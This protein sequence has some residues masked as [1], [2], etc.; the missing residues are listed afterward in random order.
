MNGGLMSGKVGS[1]PGDWERYSNQRAQSDPNWGR[2]SAPSCKRCG[3]VIPPGGANGSGGYGWR[4]LPKEY[5]SKHQSC[6]TCGKTL[7]DPNGGWSQ[8]FLRQ[9]F[10]RKCLVAQKDI[11]ERI[12][13]EKR[14]KESMVIWRNAVFGGVIFL[15]LIGVLKLVF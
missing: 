5:C 9:G 3:V 8:P 1:N 10:C 2:V 12:R 13:I 6:S 14:S 11:E 15:I 4:D 7:L